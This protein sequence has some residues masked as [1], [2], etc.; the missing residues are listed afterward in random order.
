MNKKPRGEHRADLLKALVAAE[1]ANNPWI[2]ESI[3]ACLEG[4][5]PEHKLPR[6]HPE[7]D[8]LFN[9]WN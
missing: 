5:E 3:R 6:I 7:V 9:D 2:C 8:H 1:A 4:R